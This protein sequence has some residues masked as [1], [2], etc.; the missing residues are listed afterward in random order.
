[1]TTAAVALDG[2]V[3][4]RLVADEA[5]PGRYHFAHALIRETVLGSLTAT[6]RALL[7]RRIA[8]GI[9]RLP[10]DRREPRL[11]DLARHCWMLTRWSTQVGS[12]RSC[13]A[14]PSARSTRPA[15]GHP[16][17]AHQIRQ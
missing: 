14:R 6:R 17:M 12:H 2:A 9:E 3:A 13:C 8:D 16:A 7:H 1:M 4:A 15:G 11:P 5:T 10:A